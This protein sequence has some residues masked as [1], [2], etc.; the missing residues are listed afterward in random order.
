MNTSTEKNNRRGTIS[1]LCQTCK[2]LS[3][4]DEQ[5]VDGG[6]LHAGAPLAD[7][8]SGAGEHGAEE[9]AGPVPGIKGEEDI[10]NI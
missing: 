9:Q 7:Q 1:C 5:E 4:Q 6:R 8:G 3:P 2:R 10:E